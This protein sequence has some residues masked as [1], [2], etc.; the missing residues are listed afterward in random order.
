MMASFWF[1]G[2]EVVPML[3]TTTGLFGIV[4]VLVVAFL[5]VT[6]YMLMDVWLMLLVT[7]ASRR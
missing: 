5:M 4:G 7:M 2:D 6:L 1:Q 3:F